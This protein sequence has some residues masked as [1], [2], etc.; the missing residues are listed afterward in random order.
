M[1]KAITRYSTENSIEESTIIYNF[2]R[3]ETDSSRDRDLK[4]PIRTI[5]DGVCTI[6]SI[7]YLQ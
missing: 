2:F 4:I 6:N 1:K 7:I 5:R 3:F